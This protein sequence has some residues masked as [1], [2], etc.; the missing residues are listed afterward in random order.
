[1]LNRAMYILRDEGLLSLFDR[2]MHF[3]HQQAQQHITA[4]INSQFRKLKYG[5]ASPE[6]YN[7]I[8]VDPNEIDFMTSPHFWGYISSYDTHIISGD[9]DSVDSDRIVRLVSNLE[10]YN[11]RKA[12]PIDNY[13]F[14]SSLEKHFNEDLPWESTEL[15]QYLRE[16]D[17][18]DGH[19]RYGTT[20]AIHDRLEG[21]DHLFKSMQKQGYLTQREVD[22]DDDPFADDLKETHPINPQAPPDHHEVAINIGRDGEIYFDDGRHRFA[23]ARILEI[24]SIPV[25]VFVRHQRWQTIRE[26]VAQETNPDELSGEIQEYLNH[27]DIQPLLRKSNSE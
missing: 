6:R 12:I 21:I 15:Y 7:I 11:E 18:F 10:N 9:W 1:M 4:K 16:I 24:E 3:V 25:R 26:K 17:G 8:H 22:P 2:S 5:D 23:C 19:A 14:Y 27:P 20:S 13:I